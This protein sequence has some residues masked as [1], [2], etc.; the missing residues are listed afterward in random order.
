MMNRWWTDDEQMM[1][2][3]WADDNRW[4]ADDERIMNRWW[5]D[6]E[7]MMN[8]WWTDDERIMSWW[9]ADDELMMSWWAGLL[10]WAEL[11]SLA[12]E[13]TL[14]VTIQIKREAKWLGDG[15]MDWIGLDLSQTTTTPRAPLYRAVL[16]M[17]THCMLKVLCRHNSDFDSNGDGD[18]APKRQ[19]H[20][21]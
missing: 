17:V 3:W 4:W 11:L 14:Y 21:W 19:T 18:G 2:R 13:L 8:R 15:W 1:S 16:I 5:T 6:D 12:T 20:V 7:Q 9:W 10:T